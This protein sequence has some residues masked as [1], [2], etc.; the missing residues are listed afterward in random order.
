M[1]LAHDT[2]R[3]RRTA[4]AYTSGVRALTFGTRLITAAVTGVALTHL[5]ELPNKL[6]LSADAYLVVQ[7]SIYN[8][9]GRIVGPLE[10][11]ALLG[12]GGLG[13]WRWRRGESCWLPLVAPAFIGAA[14]IVWQVH[15]GP[16]N[17]AVD[18]WTPATIPQDWTTFRARWEYAHAVRAALFTV[19]LI[20][21]LLPVDPA[22]EEN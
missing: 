21:L 14:L 2:P 1:R 20:A 19:A 11:V 4:R 22:S 5:L 18:G 9:F 3:S 7:Q 17:A 6:A 8:G 15:N 16:V 10:I 12:A 13:I